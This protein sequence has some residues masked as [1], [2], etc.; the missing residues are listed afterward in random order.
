MPLPKDSC[1]Q[2]CRQCRD[3]RRRFSDFSSERPTRWHPNK[4]TNPN[5]GLYFTEPGAWQLIGDLLEQGHEFTEKVLD[6]PPGAIAYEA[7]VRY[8]D[9]TTIY[10]K[11]EPCGP[12]IFGRSFH[13]DEPP[14]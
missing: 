6:K 7:W 5:T 9:G 2:L 12:N 13:Y 1:D 8:E 14:A 11:I 4:I 3:K 10:L